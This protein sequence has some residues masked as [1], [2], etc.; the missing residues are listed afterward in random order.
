MIS[1]FL[2]LLF[3]RA[4]SFIQLK[5]IQ[6]VINWPSVPIE[7]SPSPQHRGGGGD[8]LIDLTAYHL[9]NNLFA[10]FTRSEVI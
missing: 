5:V 9:I 8:G 7:L 4:N 6:V 2:H 3:V 10:R 1:S